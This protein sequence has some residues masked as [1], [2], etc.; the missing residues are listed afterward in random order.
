MINQAGLIE[1]DKHGESTVALA[2][3]R[4]F[5]TG[6]LLHGERISGTF[7]VSIG[8]A[9]GDHHGTTLV[10]RVIDF[11]LTGPQAENARQRG[12][13]RCRK[14]P[15]ERKQVAAAREQAELAACCAGCGRAGSIGAVE[16]ALTDGSALVLEGLVDGAAVESSVERNMSLTVEV[17]SSGVNGLAM[18]LTMFLKTDSAFLMSDALLLIRTTGILLV[19]S[20]FRRAAQTS[21]PVI[22]GRI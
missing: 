4:C 9:G 15:V 21:P 13:L 11:Q 14:R 17:R 18:D 3:Q 5:K 2:F 1:S 19:C 12:I 7:H 6:R 10:D 8:V 22:S 20:S 16:R